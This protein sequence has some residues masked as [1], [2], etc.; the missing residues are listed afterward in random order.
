MHTHRYALSILVGVFSA[1]SSVSQI[2][3]ATNPLA[4]TVEPTT[5]LLSFTPT[6]EPTKT[7][8]PTRQRVT[9]TLAPDWEGIPVIPGAFKG[10]Q[11][12][13][14]WYVYQINMPVDEVGKFYM[15]EFESRGLIL[16]YYNEGGTTAYGGINGVHIEFEKEDDNEVYQV[17][18]GF[19]PEDNSTIITLAKFRLG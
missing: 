19:Y 18:I 10:W 4:S 16:R 7:P 15:E 1:C 6:Y 11:A 3:P 13:S 8:T 17:I 5:I 9:P 12:G 14:G 2:A